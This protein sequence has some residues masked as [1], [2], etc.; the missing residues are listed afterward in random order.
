MILA[1]WF[2]FMQW[3]PVQGGRVSDGVTIWPRAGDPTNPLNR[4]RIA[5]SRDM[6][7]FSQFVRVG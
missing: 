6:A 3:L 7:C 4:V 2:W 5:A 1:P